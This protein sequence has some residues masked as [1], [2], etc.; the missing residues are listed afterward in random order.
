MR[1]LVVGVMAVA[2]MTAGAVA[3]EHKDSST[4]AADG[5]AYVTRV[6]PV[7]KTISPEAQAMLARV[8]SDAD[9]PQPLEARRKG[10]DTWQAGAGFGFGI[11]DG[12]DS[13]GEF[14]GD[15]GGCGA[16]QAGSGASVPGGPR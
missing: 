7:P 13:D 9:V 10:T 11:V 14:D 12:D 3:Q 8:V 2:L 15:E 5:T 4:I 1:R 6:V 16:V